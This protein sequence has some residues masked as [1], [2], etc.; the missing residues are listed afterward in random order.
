MRGIR[1]IMDDFCWVCFGDGVGY[2]F[3][4]YWAMF[5]SWDKVARS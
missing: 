1:I 2:V 5:G 4:M 3:W